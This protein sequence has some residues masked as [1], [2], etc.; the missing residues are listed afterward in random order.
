VGDQA[1]AISLFGALFCASSE[2]ALACH[3]CPVERFQSLQT[4]SIALQGVFWAASDAHNLDSVEDQ[5]KAIVLF[6]SSS[7]QALACHI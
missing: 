7:E 4:K 6:G 1:K 3:I 5:A 2:P